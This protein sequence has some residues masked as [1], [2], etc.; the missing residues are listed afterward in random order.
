MK[1]NKKID[2]P[3]AH[4]N[5]KLYIKA[6]AAGKEVIVIQG[7]KYVLATSK[8]LIPQFGIIA[9]LKDF[10][11]FDE[12]TGI[13][14][15]VNMNRFYAYAEALYYLH[16]HQDPVAKKAAKKSGKKPKKPV[17]IPPEDDDDEDSE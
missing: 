16:E 7:Y 4:N 14:P 5:A 6:V 9:K 11:P 1:F 8:T 17:D 10:I 3:Q 13:S 2:P 12:K 15:N